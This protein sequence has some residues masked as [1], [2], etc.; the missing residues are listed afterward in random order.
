MTDKSI[1]ISRRDFLSTTGKV[2]AGV[3]AAG[4]L[5]S[6]RQSS[7]LAPAAKVIGANDRINVGVVGVRSRGW[8][9]AKNAM[10]IKNVH[11]KAI[12]DVDGNI[13]DG[14]IAEVEKNNGYKPDA[15]KDMRKMF[16]DPDIDAVIFGTPN[17]W[18]ALCAIWACQAG[19]QVYVEKP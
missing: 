15:Y 4:V 16:E 19:K 3:L 2:S 1:P 14:R 10:G 18:H 13:L 5:T 12:C 11:L 9:L 17:H 6:C 8:E 7:T